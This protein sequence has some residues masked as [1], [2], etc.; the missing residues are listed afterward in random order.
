MSR[1]ISTVIPL[2][3]EAEHIAA[4]LQALQALR[5]QCQLIMDSGVAEAG[6]EC[7]LFLHADTQ[8]AEKSL[9]ND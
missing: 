5:E 3:N 1:T 9:S 7:L 6:G 2:L 4:K 8:F